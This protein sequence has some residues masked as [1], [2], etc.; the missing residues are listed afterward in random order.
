VKLERNRL[1]SEIREKDITWK[2][3]GE[4]INLWRWN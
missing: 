2:K 3:I 4:D 1:E